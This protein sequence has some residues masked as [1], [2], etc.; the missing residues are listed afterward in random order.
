V[1]QS[2]AR[3]LGQLGDKRAVEPLIAALGDQE[4]TVWQSA[5]RALGQLGDKRAI[6]PLRA[7]LKAKDGR[8]RSSAADALAVLGDER[9]V[10]PLLGRLKDPQYSPPHGPILEGALRQ[11]GPPAVEPLMAALKDEN[12]K[13]RHTAAVVLGWLGDERAAEPLSVA[14]RDA[15]DY[16]A[17]AAAAA[18]TEL[19]DPRGVKPLAAALK[20]Q[21]GI[22]RRSAGGPRRPAPAAEPVPVQGV[23]PHLEP[24]VRALDHEAVEVRMSAAWVLGRLGEERAVEPSL[25]KLSVRAILSGWTACKFLQDFLWVTVPV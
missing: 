24:L 12:W 7:A 21:N 5:A 20:D 25:L 1:R 23:P 6:E 10:G 9:A 16:V 13:V 17:L 22:L 2:A 14:L 18:L 11:I 15:K 3:A 19:D 8:M 4:Q